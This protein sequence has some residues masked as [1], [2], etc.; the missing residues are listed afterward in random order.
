MFCDLKLPCPVRRVADVH[1]RH[2]AALQPSVRG[3]HRCAAVG[4][5]REAQRRVAL[6]VCEVPEA[7]ALVLLRGPNGKPSE[8]M[9]VF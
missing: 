4:V 9:R 6:V 2:V 7:A 1:V 3:G 5:V 8:G